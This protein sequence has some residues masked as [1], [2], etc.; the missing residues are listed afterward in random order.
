MI[1]RKSKRVPLDAKG[2]IRHDELFRV[3]LGSK[4]DPA[5]EAWL[6]GKPLELR[7]VAKEWFEVMRQCGD[8]VCELL[9]D[10][11]PVACIDDVPFGYV[12]TYKTHVNV[13]FFRGAMLSDPSKLLV[14]TGKRM[15]HIKI[16]P[17]SAVNA[18]A[19]RALIEAAYAD[20][21]ARL[22]AE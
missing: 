13:G 20:L 3:S 11:C 21:K 4:R 14:G 17:N 15:R 19:V 5:V 18:A 8:D 16:Q 10:G 6:V 9:H 22:Q 1:E 7:A 2:L 12:N